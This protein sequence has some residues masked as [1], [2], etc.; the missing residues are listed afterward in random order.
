MMPVR[1]YLS[2]HFEVYHHSEE[3]N[4]NEPIFHLV[5]LTVLIKG[6]LLFGVVS[7]YIF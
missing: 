2:F 6:F 5:L 3:I 7:V 4:M 1:V